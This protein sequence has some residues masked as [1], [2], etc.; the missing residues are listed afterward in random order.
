MGVGAV[1]GKPAWLIMFPSTLMVPFVLCSLWLAWSAWRPGISWALF[2]LLLLLGP[3]MEFR[4]ERAQT[5]ESYAGERLRVVC[6]NAASW[7]VDLADVGR[8]TAELKPDILILQEMWWLSHLK[9]FKVGLPGL[10]FR[11]DGSGFRG[12]AIGTSYPFLDC[13]LPPPDGVLGGVISVGGQSVLILSL[14]GL[15]S[16]SGLSNPM[17]TA[18][19][20][21]RQAQEVLDYIEAVG[22][23]TVLGG[24]FNGIPSAPLGRVFALKLQDVFWLEGRGYG[25]TFPSKFPLTRLD[26]VMLTEGL[27]QVESFSLVDVGSDHLALV[28][29]LR[30]KKT[31]DLLQ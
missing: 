4:R 19:R 20:Q 13:P 22:L 5:E 12:L 27:A 3:L 6:L 9:G 31:K 18:L 8:R 21:E 30:L 11:G 14:H 1:L 17:R 25:Y 10:S 16:S 23:P 26:R 29:D 15:K 2:V 7:E 28:L 24:D